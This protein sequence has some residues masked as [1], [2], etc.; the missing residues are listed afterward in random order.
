MKEILSHGQWS[1]D[2][3]S[4]HAFDGKLAGALLQMYKDV[5]VKNIIDL[6][7]GPG[8]YVKFLKEYGLDTIGVDGNP[9]TK[10]FNSELL[11]ADLAEPQDFGKK[12]DAVMSLEVGEHIPKEF[13]KTFL[14]N[15]K[16][17]STKW[18]VL[19]WAVPK[20]NGFGHVNCQPNDYI[21]SEMAAS[22]FVFQ[23]DKTA[24]LRKDASLFWFKNTIMVF[25]KQ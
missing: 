1:G 5:G 25:C 15:I 9:G 21:I 6:G 7:C 23:P 22:G 17:H 3:I 18:V 16:K 8:K 13:E 2:C 11:V 14:D 12:W 20:Q 19:S 4:Q 10:E 24:G